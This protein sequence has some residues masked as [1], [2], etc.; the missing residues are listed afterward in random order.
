MVRN[1]SRKAN[2]LDGESRRRIHRQLEEGLYDAEG[3]KVPR[4]H[5]YLQPVTAA[6]FSVIIT[7][8]GGFSSPTPAPSFLGTVAILMDW[9]AVQ[10]LARQHP[11]SLAPSDRQP[12]SPSV[13][14]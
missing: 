13:A 2:K 12:R 14:P 11:G 7:K 3:R 1:V 6:L 9:T 4:H 5:D 10:Q 8:E